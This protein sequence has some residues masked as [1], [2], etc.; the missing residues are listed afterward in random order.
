M[1]SSFIIY[2]YQYLLMVRFSGGESRV[3]SFPGEFTTQ[4][5]YK[6]FSAHQTSECVGIRAFRVY[7]PTGYSFQEIEDLGVVLCAFYARFKT[8]SSAISKHSLSCSRTRIQEYQG[9]YCFYF[10]FFRLTTAYY[11]LNSELFLLAAFFFF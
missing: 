11:N 4:G 6:S 10:A 9:Q 1:T 3:E 7:L 5:S 2:Q 8:R